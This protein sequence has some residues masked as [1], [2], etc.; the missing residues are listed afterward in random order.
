MTRGDVIKIEY[1][2]KNYYLSIIE[3]KPGNAISIIETDIELDF[4][5]PLDY[6]EPVKGN[7]HILIM[8]I[9][10]L[11]IY[12]YILCPYFVCIESKQEVKPEDKSTSKMDIDEED[13]ASKTRFRAF[14]GSG[15][16][17]K[18]YVSYNHLI[19]L[20]L[21]IHMSWWLI[22]SSYPIIII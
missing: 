10:Y 16:S 17:L 12:C 1:N 15:H 5:P 19:A 7:T 14:S 2:K 11:H 18:A 3:T 9:Q 8:I 20:H 4:A 6:V 22:W 13:E 21:P